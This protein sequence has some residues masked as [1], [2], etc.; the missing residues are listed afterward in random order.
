MAIITNVAQ[1]ASKIPTFNDLIRHG[2][3]ASVDAKTTNSKPLFAFVFDYT[4]KIFIKQYRVKFVLL[5]LIDCY[6]LILTNDEGKIGRYCDFTVIPRDVTKPLTDASNW[7]WIANGVGICLVSDNVSQNIIYFGTEEDDSVEI[8]CRLQQGLG[9]N[10]ERAQIDVITR[11]VILESL[12]KNVAV[13]ESTENRRKR[14][15]DEIKKKESSNMLCLPSPEDIT[16]PHTNKIDYMK[17][18]ERYARLK[19]K[20]RT[21]EV[22]VTTDVVYV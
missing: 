1:I 22:T 4:N 6:V 15:A 18:L 9:G 13:L 10:Y 3:F 16:A 21:E 2:N 7:K 19:Y 5:G 8:R 14:M 12:K 17:V 20:D 11:D